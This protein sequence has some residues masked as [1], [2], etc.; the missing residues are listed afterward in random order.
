MAKSFNREE[1]LNFLVSNSEV[2]NEDDRA[3]L[4][5]FSDEVLNAFVD[6]AD[7]DED[8]EEEE[9]DD[10][11]AEDADDEEESSETNE[12][13]VNNVK[14]RKVK[15]TEDEEDMEENGCGKKMTKNSAPMS[16][17]EWLASA[18]ASVRRVVTNAMAMEKAQKDQL[19]AKIVAN[20]N[21]TFTEKFLETKDVEE[22][23]AIATLAGDNRSAPTANYGVS[24]PM[25]R[26]SANKKSE[27]L[28]IP[29]LNWEKDFK[30]DN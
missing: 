2:F 24:V 27:P 20:A 19:I 5:K 15:S 22:L 9:E 7:E 1:V 4:D 14:R 16:E 21:N 25:T 12:E 13:R 8:E 17:K 23:T 18:P 28:T 6:N 10:E 29:T 11:E 26:N 3:T 30:G